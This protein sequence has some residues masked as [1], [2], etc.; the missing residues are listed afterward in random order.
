MFLFS[1][2]YLNHPEINSSLLLDTTFLTANVDFLDCV[3]TNL[4]SLTP[5]VW[6]KKD[7]EVLIFPSCHYSYKFSVNKNERYHC[8]GMAKDGELQVYKYADNTPWRHTRRIIFQNLIDTESCQSFYNYA[9]QTTLLVL[10]QQMNHTDRA[11]QV[12]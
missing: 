9:L 11:Y 2:L 1:S 12:L 10:K 6:E 8:H 4:S 5:M 3:V 7:R